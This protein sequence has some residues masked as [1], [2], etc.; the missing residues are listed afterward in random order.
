MSAT[1]VSL[2]VKP[3]YS[4]KECVD[5]G[6]S[7]L[8]HASYQHLL[9]LAQTADVLVVVAPLT[10]CTVQE[11]GEGECPKSSVIHHKYNYTREVNMWL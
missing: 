5:G 2:A 6:L 10:G 1:S 9:L 7:S 3:C 4:V 8:G 11:C